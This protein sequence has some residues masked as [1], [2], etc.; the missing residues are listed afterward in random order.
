M[1][2]DSATTDWLCTKPVFYNEKTGAI[3]YNMRDVIDYSDFAFSAE[4]LKNYLKFGYSVYG[5]TMIEN[6]KSLEH[7]SNIEK[8]AQG[9]LVITQADDIAEKLWNP[10]RHNGTEVFESIIAA[11]SDWAGSQADSEIVLPLSGGFDSRLLAYSVRGNKNVKSYSYGLSAKQENSFEVVKAKQVAKSCEI[12]WRSIELDEFLREDYLDRWYK[13]YGPSVHLHGM[14]QMEFYDKILDRSDK[15][16]SMLSGIIGD[17]WAGTVRISGIDNITSLAKLGYTHG[18]SVDEN[19]CLLKGE[20]HCEEAFFDKHRDKL[21][22]EN[23]RILYA[24][25]FKMMLLNYLLKTPEYLGMDTWSPFLE[26]EIAMSILN[27]SWEE[28]TD[29]IWQQR[30][31]DKLGLNIGWEKDKCDYNMVLDIETLRK[32][33]VRPLNE[34][35]LGRV[36]NPE[37]VAEVNKQILRKPMRVIPAKPRTMANMYNKM[38]KKYNK[39]ID[40]ALI[41]YEILGSIERLMIEAEGC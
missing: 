21:R 25:R 6:V 36:I 34:K 16:H 17:G 7:S 10:E 29:R 11:T 33:P 27:L 15:K 31:F 3:S 13:L 12:D 9:K 14:Y 23:W 40:E 37:Y 4:G 41:S 20:N 18:M 30:E 26:P 8:D 39:L 24:M 28:K 1:L 38:V 22:D 32:N 2:L 5:Q 19:V 35:L